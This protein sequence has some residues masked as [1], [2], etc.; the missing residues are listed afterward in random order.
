MTT[1]NLTKIPKTVKVQALPYIEPRKASPKVL[2]YKVV[3][4]ELGVMVNRGSYRTL[5]G[6]ISKAARVSQEHGTAM[7]YDS[8]LTMGSRMVRL[9]K[10]G[11]DYM[12]GV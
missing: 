1:L 5:A 8:S 7:I 3:V 4:N 11:V 2:P 6:A 12:A 10:R 9:F